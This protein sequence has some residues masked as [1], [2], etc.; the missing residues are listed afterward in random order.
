MGRPSLS[1]F[2]LWY[3]VWA[4]GVLPVSAWETNSHSF[5]QMDLED[6]DPEFSY[7]KPKARLGKK[8]QKRSVPAPMPVINTPEDFWKWHAKQVAHMRKK[9]MPLMTEQQK[10]DEAW[11]KFT[12][13]KKA[14]EAAKKVTGPS[15][16]DPY[17]LPAQ[18]SRHGYR[19]RPPSEQA[20]PKDDGL[21]G[22]K[23]G[24]ARTGFVPPA[25]TAAQL[26]KNPFDDKFAFAA[27][28]GPYGAQD[29]QQAKYMGGKDDSASDLPDSDGGV[30][31]DEPGMGGGPG[32]AAAGDLGGQGVLG[33][34]YNSGDGKYLP[35]SG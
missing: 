5:K 22:A 8:N 10:M 17:A 33:N 3:S 13:K 15:P 7:S 31:Q 12:N 32:D 21:H 19:P 4:V 20:V 9:I 28:A 11:D 30:L 26:K 29:E 25:P 6:W 2:A 35:M 23:K 27:G 1:L 14:V 24:D 34:E 18:F 16:E